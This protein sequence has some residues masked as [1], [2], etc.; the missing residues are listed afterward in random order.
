MFESGI[1]T[2]WENNCIQL[3]DPTTAVS[4]LWLVYTVAGNASVVVLTVGWDLGFAL[5]AG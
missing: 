4:N 2:M 3:G 1:E 5:L